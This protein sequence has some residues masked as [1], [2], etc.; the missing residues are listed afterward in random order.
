VGRTL[1]VV[2]VIG[3]GNSQIQDEYYDAGTITFT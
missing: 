2:I 1:R 3:S